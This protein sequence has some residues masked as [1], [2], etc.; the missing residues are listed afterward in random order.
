M[1]PFTF[2]ASQKP[3]K[4]RIAFV[5][6]VSNIR[7]FKQAYAL[8]KYFPDQYELVLLVTPFENPVRSLNPKVFDRVITYNTLDELKDRLGAIK[9]DLIHYH[10]Q[11]SA[12]ACGVVTIQS[13]PCPVIMDI[14]DSY[15]TM[16][17]FDDMPEGIQSFQSE[18]YCIENCDG[19]IYKGTQREIDFYRSYFSLEVPDLHFMDYCL[20]DFIVN[21]SSGH[22][23]GRG[24]AISIVY[25]GGVNPMDDPKEFFANG[26]FDGVGKL[27]ASLGIDFHI[28]PNPFPS[29]SDRYQA[30]QELDRSTAHFH[31]HESVPYDALNFKMSQHNYGWWVHFH[32][33][34]TKVSKRQQ[35]NAIGAKFFTYLEAGLPVIVSDNIGY[36]VQLLHQYQLGIEIRKD[37][38][39]RMDTMLAAVDY[40]ALKE[41]VVKHRETT[42]NMREHISRLVEF[43]EKILG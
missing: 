5:C 25:A 26:Q 30:Y 28:Y 8:K 41:N 22:G 10:S 18:R 39:E 9:P 7:A 2:H 20:D 19:L 33:P 12:L 35:S 36:G 43:Y 32:P 37:D 31:F 27:I 16:Y 34:N 23:N 17:N 6:W 29:Q 38:L 13:A 11:W 42:F 40:K 24:D 15:H 21:G 14:Y 4:P 3:R 1:N